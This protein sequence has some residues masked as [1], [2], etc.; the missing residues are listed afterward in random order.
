MLSRSALI[1]LGSGRYHQLPP[2]PF[3]PTTANVKLLAKASQTTTMQGPRDR[4]AYGLRKPSRPLQ[5]S[6]Q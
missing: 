6:V 2:T 3:E 4:D 5:Y 1:R